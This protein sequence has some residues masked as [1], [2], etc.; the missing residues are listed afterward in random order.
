MNNELREVVVDGLDYIRSVMKNLSL[1]SGSVTSGDDLKTVK[2]YND[3]KEG[4]EWIG[5]VLNHFQHFLNLDYSEL[6][7][8]KQTFEK[9]IVEYKKFMQETDKTFQAGDYNKLSS[10]IQEQLP[11][12]FK[13]IIAI[14]NKIKIIMNEREH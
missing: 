14:F 2:N 11:K 12:H 1:L 3:L 10:Y 4:F 13:K 5:G 9:I 7:I 6:T 8:N